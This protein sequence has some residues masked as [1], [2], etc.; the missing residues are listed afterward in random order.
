MSDSKLDELERELKELDREIHGGRGYPGVYGRLGE[1]EGRSEV[2]S[3]QIAGVQQ[4][5]R[6]TAKALS[7]LA[8]ALVAYKSSGL[9]PAAV[10]FLCLCA[11]ASTLAFAAIAAVTVGN[12]MQSRSDIDREEM[13]GVR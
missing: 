2:M 8:D 1:M 13:I 3:E 9:R 6:D 10:L 5:N 12:S 4:D 11:L 7:A